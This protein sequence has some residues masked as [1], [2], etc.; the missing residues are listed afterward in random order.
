MLTVVERS[1]EGEMIIVAVNAGDEPEAFTLPLSD[2]QGNR[3]EILWGHDTVEHS[4]A[5][6]RLTLAP[7]SGSIWRI[8]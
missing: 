6:A 1:A 2:L 5:E 7:R 4:D 3:L 8:V